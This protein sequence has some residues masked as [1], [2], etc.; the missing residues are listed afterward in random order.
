MNK[1]WLTPCEVAEY[2]SVSKR[3][4]YRLIDDGKLQ[5]IKIR[6]S[7]RIKGVSVDAFIDEQL[8]I[9]ALKAGI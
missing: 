8:E 3:T 4:I 7:M 1:A 2:L 5:A 6:G 9:Q